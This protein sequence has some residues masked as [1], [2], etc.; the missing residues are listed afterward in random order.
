MKDKQVRRELRLKKTTNAGEASNVDLEPAVD[1]GAG[2]REQPA[3]PHRQTEAGE[4]A[5]LLYKMV[6]RFL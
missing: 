6:C 5:W 4:E 2:L 1:R 3:Q